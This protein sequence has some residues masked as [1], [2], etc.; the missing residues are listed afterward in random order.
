LAKVNQKLMENNRKDSTMAAEL[1]DQIREL[2]IFGHVV[3]K[4]T[5]G[6]AIADMRKPD[7]PLIYVN[8]A[9][10]VITGYGR[11]LALGF[12]CRFLQGPDT[13]AVELQKLR[14]AI[15][16]GKPYSGE[17]INYR[18]DGSRF[19][20]RLTIYPIYGAHQDRPDYYV[21][22]QVDISL[23]KQQTSPLSNALTTIKSDFEKA[24]SAL[25]QALRFSEGMH[26]YLDK[27]TSVVPEV[28]AF[29]IAEREAHQLLEEAIADLGVVLFQS[30]SSA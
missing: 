13:D 27:K 11:E 3:D 2:S 18:V 8:D 14:Q 6:I 26:R 10:T 17:L 4:A 16:Q 29:L 23:L 20:N 15:Q 21:G 19:W 5:F 7:S 25:E 9:F 24:Q 30:G 22:N 12:N 28:E 1:V